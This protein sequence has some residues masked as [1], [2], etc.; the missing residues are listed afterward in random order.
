[1][2]DVLGTIPTTLRKEGAFS[3]A[4]RIFLNELEEVRQRAREHA[5]EEGPPDEL[6]EARRQARRG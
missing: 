1:M 4:A 6:R 5:R 2:Q 3:R